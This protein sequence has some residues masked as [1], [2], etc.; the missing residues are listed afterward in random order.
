M[1]HLIN[2]IAA[3]LLTFAIGLA[4]VIIVVLADKWLE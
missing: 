2:F 3:G 4:I 1:E